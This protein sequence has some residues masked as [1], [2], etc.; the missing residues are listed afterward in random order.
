MF[1]QQN[2]TL[3]GG[4]WWIIIIFAIIFG[5]G[6]GGGLFGGR[7]DSAQDGYILTSDFANIER[8]ID[9]VNNG[10]CEGFYTQAQL[11]NGV[12]QN[13]A[14]G[15][16]SAELTRANNQ[17]AIMSQM[18]ANAM[19]Q[20]QSDFGIQS[21]LSSCCCENRQAIS[22]VNYNMATNTRDI[23]DSQN[24]NTRAILDALNQNKVDELN[25]RIAEQTQTINALQLS[26]S[27]AAQNNC[28]INALRPSPIPAYI[29]QNPYCNCAYAYGTTIS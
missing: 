3:G 26:A 17:A 12:N 23:I 25:Q 28:I 18:N 16:A 8:K 14:N 24:A 22:G 27:Q 15:F 1:S 4:G 9:G 13:L 5:W 7:G 19:A 29:T 2:D 11:V 21:S 6:N 20:M 10:L